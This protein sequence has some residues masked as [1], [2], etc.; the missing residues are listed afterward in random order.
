MTTLSLER[1]AATG[2]P[3]RNRERGGFELQKEQEITSFQSK[4][5]GPFD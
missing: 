1:K 4:V 2:T 3:R 5:G